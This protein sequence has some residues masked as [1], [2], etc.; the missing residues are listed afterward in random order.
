MLN[1]F[2]FVISPIGERGSPSRRRADGIL[3]EVIRP[4]LEPKGYRV[5]R[6][7]HDKS[8]GVVTEAFI[9]KIFNAD[10]VV[11]DLTGLNPNVMYELAVR[12][13]SGKPV[14]QILEDGHELPFDVRSQNTLYFTCDLA[15]RTDAIRNIQAAE[16]A[17]HQASDLGN[18]IKRSVELRGLAT[19]GKGQDSVVATAIVEMQS[20]LARLYGAVQA[21]SGRQT[22]L[23]HIDDLADAAWRLANSTAAAD[24]S[25]TSEEDLRELQRALLHSY[26]TALTPTQESFFE[27]RMEEVRAEL[28]RRHAH[29][30]GKTG[31]KPDAV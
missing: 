10:L 6:A 31:V 28:E 4:A 3:N 22:P 15:G 27:N 18:P 2:C 23:Q 14:I 17:V 1:R 25:S 12:H 30:S 7:D 9:A 20:Q 29:R 8:P 5:E 26:N 13:A 19:S 24:L 21:L 11:A 16:E